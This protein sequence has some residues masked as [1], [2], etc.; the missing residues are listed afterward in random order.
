MYDDVTYVYDDVTYVYDDEV[1][2]CYIL[3]YLDALT[4][5]AF[6][7]SETIKAWLVS[8]S[9]SLSLS[10]SLSVSLSLCLSL[11]LSRSLS[12]SLKHQCSLRT[13]RFR[14]L[15]ISSSAQGITVLRS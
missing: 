14:L 1:L 9:L 5:V 13:H 6:A 4:I 7:M 2:V 10:L 11:S 12:L 3:C 15:L 8:V